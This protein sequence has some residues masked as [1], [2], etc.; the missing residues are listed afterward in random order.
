MK[1]KLDAISSDGKGGRR[2]TLS[3][4]SNRCVYAILHAWTPDRDHTVH[5]VRGHNT[6]ASA[7]QRSCARRLRCASS[8]CT[9]TC[10]CLECMFTCLVVV[11]IPSYTPE[12]TSLTTQFPDVRGQM[13]RASA[14]V[15][16]QVALCFVCIHTSVQNLKL[17]SFSV[18][19]SV[20]EYDRAHY[21]ERLDTQHAFRLLRQQPK[22]SAV[23]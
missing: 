10:L 3:M 20:I 15:R 13:T 2:R 17:I 18:I 8:A 5:N 4:R 16:T 23:R 14:S 12:R 1:A 21:S 22:C 7:S 19:D 11:R 9:F 6:H